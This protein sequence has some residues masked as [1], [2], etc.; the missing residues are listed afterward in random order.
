MR[1]PNKEKERYFH[2][3]ETTKIEKNHFPSIKREEVLEWGLAPLFFYFPLPFLREE[4]QGDGFIK[5]P[6]LARVERKL[7]M[8]YNHLLTA[9]SI[10]H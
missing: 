5:K 3:D 6:N 2:L 7:V 10:G 1:N 8:R 9:I 4:G